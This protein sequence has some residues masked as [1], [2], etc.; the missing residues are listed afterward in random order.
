MDSFT[1]EVI[2]FL[3]KYLCLWSIIAWLKTSLAL[4]YKWIVSF[5]VA[6]RATEGTA[7]TSKSKYFGFWIYDSTSSTNSFFK[8]TTNLGIKNENTIR[9]A[10]LKNVWKTANFIAQSSG[11]IPNAADK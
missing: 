1:I 4:S 9:P 3:P 11:A 5:L 2:S 7:T 8:K 6:S 10:R